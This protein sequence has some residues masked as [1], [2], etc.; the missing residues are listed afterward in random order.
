MNRKSIYL[1]EQKHQ[2]INKY[3]LDSSDC[4]HLCKFSGT[5]MKT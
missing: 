5:S 3:K 1:I 4:I 2:Q